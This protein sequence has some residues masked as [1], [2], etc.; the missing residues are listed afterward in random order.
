MYTVTIILALIG[1]LVGVT[2]LALCVASN[3]DLGDELHRE[4]GFFN[5]QER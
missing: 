4:Q 2:G 3:D 1:L 5:D